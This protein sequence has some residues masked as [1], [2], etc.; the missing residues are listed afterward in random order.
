MSIRPLA[1]RRTLV[2]RGA[3]IFAA[4]ALALAGCAVTRT[5]QRPARGSDLALPERPLD[6]AVRGTLQ[7]CD[8]ARVNV[9]TGT[10]RDADPCRRGPVD[11][12]VRATVDSG[13]ST[14]KVP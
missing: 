8:T 4:G 14:A 9:R 10:A 11:T 2:T 3:V 7:R 6:R 5:P 13:G 12:L 1:G